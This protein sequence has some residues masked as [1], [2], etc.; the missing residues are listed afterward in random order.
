MLTAPR[1][2]A[3]AV[4]D[5]GVDEWGIEE[6][7]LYSDELEDDMLLAPGGPVPDGGAD[8]RSARLPTNAQPNAQ[9]NPKPIPTD[10]KETTKQRTPPSQKGTTFH[11]RHNKDICMHSS[12]MLTFFSRDNTCSFLHA[13]IT[14]RLF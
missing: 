6:R 11:N 14:S 8:M 7:K 12:R 2:S 10:S 5:N 3:A 4:F 1:E 13:E 9:R